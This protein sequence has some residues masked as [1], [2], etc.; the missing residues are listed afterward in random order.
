MPVTQRMGIY[1]DDYIVSQSLSMPAT[2]LWA[3]AAWVAVGLVALLLWFSTRGRLVAFGISWF[4]VAH[5]VESTVL[6]LEMYFEH[7]NYAPAIG[8]LLA[9]G[10]V[11]HIVT[12]RWRAVAPP[13][14]VWLALL[15]G[16]FALQTSPLVV[17]WS[18]RPLLNLHHYTGHPGS[19][20]A[21]NDMASQMAVHGELQAAL[22]FSTAAHAASRNKAAAN[23][24]HSDYMVR[25]L[26][27]S[28]IADKPPVPG[29][30]A[31]LGSRDPGRP[32]SSATTLLT[33]VRLLQDDRC[34]H[35]DRVA[36]ADRMAQLLLVDERRRGAS[37]IYSSMAVLENALGRYDKAYAYIDHVLRRSPNNRQALLM[38][39]HFAT[40][41]NRLESKAE[42]IAQLTALREAGKLNTAQQQ[43]LDLYLEK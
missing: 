28:C 12:A 15:A 13:L 17:I 19:A 16:W 9:L 20:R 27:L 29:T 2:T 42:V 22:E 38:K 11:F 4:V 31:Q 1:H 6:P 37:R 21:N 30:I 43:T 41:L 5:G 8:L 10:G 14:L 35:I 40:A 36:F 33:M 25:N 32:L 18:S 24:R 23:E 3:V 7:R 34:P 26:A 39:L